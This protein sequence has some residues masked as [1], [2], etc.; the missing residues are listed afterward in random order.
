[1]HTDK[2]FCIFEYFEYI[3]LEYFATL[4]CTIGLK[5]T[6]S[7]TTGLKSVNESHI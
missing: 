6:E 7:K 1:M 4:K 3:K 5:M 2:N